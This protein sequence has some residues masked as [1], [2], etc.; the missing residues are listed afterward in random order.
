MK[1]ANS[2]LLEIAS[3]Y[4]G[5]PDLFNYWLT[6]EKAAEF[7]HATTTQL[8]NPRTND[9]DREILQAI[10][11]RPEI[12]PKVVLSGTRVGEYKGIPV[13][14]PAAH[15]TGSAVVGTPLS[16]ADAAYLSSGTWSLIGLE[17]PEAVINDDCYEANVTN[18]GGAYGTYRF[19][20]NVMGLWLTQ[21]SRATWQ[22]R[23]AEYS[24]DQ[25]T[26]LAEQAEPFRSFI[27]PDDPVFL[28]PGDIPERVREFCARTNQPVPETEGQVLRTI[29]ES[30][31]MKYRETLSRL[32]R[33][34]GQQIPKLHIIGG[35]TRNTLLCQMT[36]D[37]INRPVVA[38]PVE[39]TA[40]GNACVQ[41]ISLGWIDNIAEARTII[42]QSFAMT[43]YEPQNV[44]QWDQAFERFQKVT[45][46]N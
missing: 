5:L 23:G 46:G 13:I 21:Q 40:L 32:S 14:V 45:R 24:Y 15:D 26:A 27:D 36:A 2:P 39:A 3:T 31:A 41:M 35:G 10:G 7:T 18:E 4:L 43:A 16:S 19:L 17:L 30:L 29:Y 11:I 8:Y 1:R 6:G 12:F 20:K 42:G 22:T 44:A 34:S 33:L 37:A 28:P 9:W 25:L 38:G